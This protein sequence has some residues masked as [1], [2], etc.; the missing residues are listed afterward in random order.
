MSNEYESNSNDYS[1][2]QDPSYVPFDSNTSDDKMNDQYKPFEV[3][4]SSI[5]M[6]CGRYGKTGFSGSNCDIDIDECEISNPCGDKAGICSNTYGSYEC[7]CNLGFKLVLDPSGDQRCEDI[8][9]C[10]VVDDICGDPRL[11]ITCINQQ[12]GFRCACDNPNEIYY[13]EKCI[14]KASADQSAV[15][16]SNAE[17]PF[18]EL[19]QCHVGTCDGRPLKY[20]ISYA[21]CCCELGNKWT[22]GDDQCSMCPQRTSPQWNDLCQLEVVDFN[23]PSLSNQVRETGM[24]HAELVDKE[25]LTFEECCCSTKVNPLWW[26]EN[27]IPCSGTHQSDFHEQCPSGNGAVNGQDI[28]ECAVFGEDNLCPSG[29]CIDQPKGFACTCDRTGYYWTNGKCAN[30][31]ECSLPAVYCNGGKCQDTEGSYI[32]TCPQGQE[33]INGRCQYPPIPA[34]NSYSSSSEYGLSGV[35]AN[36]PKE[37]SLDFSE[38]NVCF[39]TTECDMTSIQ[40]THVSHSECCCTG[41]GA[42][43]KEMACV[44]C[45]EQ[46]T[47]EYEKLCGATNQPEEEPIYTEPPT[48]E[49][50]TVENET[51]DNSIE[52]MS[53]ESDL[54]ESDDYSDLYDLP[55][56]SIYDNSIYSSSYNDDNSLISDQPKRRFK[57]YKANDRAKQDRGNRNN[58]NKAA[59][60]SD[61]QPEKH[62]K[63]RGAFACGLPGGCGH[64]DCVKSPRGVTCMCHVS[65][66]KNQMGRCI[67][68]K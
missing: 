28:D 3:E 22:T 42:W 67:T 2:N 59:P 46:F 1:S 17:S 26:G 19:G 8:N 40:D 61:P 62:G 23:K 50:V 6:E 52:D 57:P 29:R 16:E 30:F 41:G 14:K 63:S 44:T 60:I 33:E 54:S 53:D 13:H 48:E 11:G 21:K 34:L 9:E 55:E 58:S 64:G 12:G 51:D 68:R 35:A 7:K 31:D 45:P 27:R 38:K 66:T 56:E 36:A 37:G 4:T 47:P 25:G 24:C 5:D 49:S 43:G 32:C 65:W 10:E 39:S 18:E 15:T 20:G